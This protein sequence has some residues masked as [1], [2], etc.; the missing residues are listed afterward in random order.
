MLRHFVI[1]VSA[2]LLIY[3]PVSILAASASAVDVEI[4]SFSSYVK[5]IRAELADVRAELFRLV[6]YKRWN[7]HPHF[8]SSFFPGAAAEDSYSVDREALESDLD[9]QS[10]SATSA[11]TNKEELKSL[12][13]EE[14]KSLPILLDNLKTEWRKDMP[15]EPPENS[16]GNP[17]FNPKI[18]KHFLRQ[19]LV[20]GIEDRISE[21]QPKTLLSRLSSPESK[22]FK[23]VQESLQTDDVKAINGIVSVVAKLII[24]QQTKRGLIQRIDEFY[25]HTLIRTEHQKKYPQSNPFAAALLG[26]CNKVLDFEGSLEDER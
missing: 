6:Q 23:Y 26:I 2:F 15:P 18:F 5:Q 11:D 24:N 13:K 12:T 10:Y 4:N 9:S 16:C 20:Y 7:S 3:L 14:L 8:H 25:M 22:L 17:T 21:L 19:C 1:V